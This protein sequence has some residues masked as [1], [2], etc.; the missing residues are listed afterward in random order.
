LALD[1]KNGYQWVKGTS[2]SSAY[3]AGIA[4]LITQAYKEKYGADPAP[5]QVLA[6]LKEISSPLKSV[7]AGKQGFGLP[8]ASKIRRAV[9]NLDKD[10]K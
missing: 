1:N 2:F 4:I 8:D 10:A 5:Q 9:K 6:V 7:P 3:V